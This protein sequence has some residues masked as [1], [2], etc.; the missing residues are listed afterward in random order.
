MELDLANHFKELSEKAETEIVRMLNQYDPQ[1]LFWALVAST[2]IPVP[3]TQPSIHMEQ[4]P[5]FSLEILASFILDREFAGTED[6]FYPEVLDDLRRCLYQSSLH[7]PQLNSSEDKFAAHIE[8]Q[9]ALLRGNAFGWQTRNRIIQLFKRYDKKIEE[10]TGINVNKI[11]SFVDSYSDYILKK[12]RDS[13]DDIVSS[14]EFALIISS[15]SEKNGKFIFTKKDDSKKVFSNEDEVR[16]YI[17]KIIIGNFLYKDLLVS[18]E[19]CQD[20]SL[21]SDEFQAISSLIGVS[22]DI[23]HTIGDIRYYPLIQ[24]DNKSILLTQNSALD[25]ILYHLDNMIKVEYGD[26]FKK[27]KANYTENM[28]FEALCRIF[29]SENIYKN[30]SYPDPTK[31]DVKST[32]EL[33][34]AVKYGRFLILCEIKSKQLREESL[35]GD[36]SKL[37]SDLKANIEDSYKQAQRAIKYI[38]SVDEAKFTEIKSQRLLQV[39]KDDIDKIYI[40]SACYEPLADIGT[41]LNHTHGLSLFIDKNYPFSI[42]I[43]DLDVISYTSI[44]PA[45]LLHYI[46]R[47]LSILQDSTEWHGDELDLFPAY[48]DSR[49]LESN[50]GLPD[51]K[52]I[53]MLTFTGYSGVFEDLDGF[54]EANPHDALKTLSLRI[55]NGVSELFEELATAN[56]DSAKSIL[57]KLH[58]FSN[59]SLHKLVT[60]IK[61]LKSENI[62]PQQFRRFSFQDGDCAVNIVGTSHEPHESLAIKT[63]QRLLFEKY[64]CKSNRSIAFAVDTRTNRLVEFA[65]YLESQ[66]IF[67]ES[68]ERLMAQDD[69]GVMTFSGKRP[70]RNEKCPCGSGKKFKKCCLLLLQQ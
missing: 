9:H 50:L 49:L 29:R 36:K 42:S 25:A 22:K 43:N 16:Q 63:Q 46:E 5:I 41:R 55:P 70:G 38:E 37:R 66:W 64:R 59:E 57:F 7:L 26:K 39:K 3:G 17:D 15:I 67:D 27:F 56:N 60:V 68:M 11:V 6:F 48:L 14:P 23:F 8:H 34:I 45:S 19:N 52:P 18:T 10:R 47:R 54:Y 58:E 28:A 4:H 24:I 2:Y 40:V 61:K 35:A 62:P 69:R 44:Y 32:A 13:W 12:T 65:Q 1:K 51:D 20:F 30:L 53:N 33:D 31:D 21:S